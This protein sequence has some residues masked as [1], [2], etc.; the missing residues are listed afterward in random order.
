MSLVIILYLAV[1]LVFS[2]GYFYNGV[3]LL[4]KGNDPAG[5]LRGR[6]ILKVQDNDEWDYDKFRKHSGWLLIIS[7]VLSAAI[8]A[9]TFIGVPNITGTLTTREIH[10]VRTCIIALLTLYFFKDM[11]LAAFRDSFVSRV[12]TSDS[13]RYDFKQTVVFTVLCATL[14]YSIY[15]QITYPW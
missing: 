8:L 12:E 10:F 5:R 15:T 2:G 6:S 3:S 7:G 4:V 14:I 13:S 1:L 11:W 9:V